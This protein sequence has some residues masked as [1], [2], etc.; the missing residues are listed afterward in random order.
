MSE[1]RLQKFLSRAGIA[2]RRE[3]EDLIIAGKVQIN[4]RVAKLGDKVDP[5]VDKVIVGGRRVVALNDF[6]YL[7]MYKPAGL[8]TSREGQFGRKTVYDLLP[9]DLRKKVWA[10]GR[11]DFESEGLLIFTNDGELTQKLTHPSFEHAKEYEAVLNK[12]L[13]EKDKQTLE[14]GVDIGEALTAPA[15]VKILSNKKAMII[16]HEGQKRQ[17]RRM[18]EA[19]GY[20]LLKLTRARI[21]K[22]KLDSL[23]LKTGE[24]K[25]INKG[26]II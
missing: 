10:V 26:D 14:K 4:G 25:K 23:K 18:F 21:A 1:E 3:A 24:I 6:L 15:K 12:N 17:V 5:V 22:L 2:S 9:K 13:L 8:I 11:L 19:V 7:A 20:K 16:I